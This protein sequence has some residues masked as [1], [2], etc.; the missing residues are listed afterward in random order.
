M[1][2]P[3]RIPS[4]VVPAGWGTAVA[5]GAST[6][7]LLFS[8]LT[9]AS[10]YWTRRDLGATV[11]PPRAAV[12]A[13]VDVWVGDIAPGVKAVLSAEW[14][15]PDWDRLQDERWNAGF[16]ADV[17]PGLA[18]YA[19]LAFNTSAAPVELSFPEGA[20][21]IVAPPP[22]AGEPTPPGGAPLAVGS[23]DLGAWLA[24]PAIAASSA[25]T[26]LRMLGADRGT[27][28][29]PPGKMLRRPVAF[30]RRVPLETAASVSRSDGTAFHRR[31]MRRSEWAGLLAS[32]SVEQIR[33]L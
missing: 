29:I 28:A 11:L 33:A 15:H 30:P 6:A 22:A 27:I 2:Q 31:R 14:N 18:F 7:L 20:L 3:R 8:A 26:T 19:L 1:P 13:E 16:G 32:P 17:A 4:K 9:V 25:A 24:K 21:R 23:L 10:T 5:L 12:P